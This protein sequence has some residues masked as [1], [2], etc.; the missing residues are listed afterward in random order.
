LTH[1]S[2]IRWSGSGIHDEMNLRGS[3]VADKCIRNCLKTDH[4][5]QG[6]TVTYQSNRESTPKISLRTQ[7]ISEKLRRLAVKKVE[8][9]AFTPF[10]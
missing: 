4:S 8:R 3:F 10:F 2:K 6:G 7:I 5:P 1:L 9:A